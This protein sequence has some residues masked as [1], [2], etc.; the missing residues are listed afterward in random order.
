MNNVL[1]I[2]LTPT[3][4]QY[5]RLEALQQ[6][7]SQACNRLAPVV[8]QTRCWNR[9]ALHHLAY[10]SLRTEFPGLG[11]QMAC[12]AIYAV[13]KV[14]RH[15]Y[16]HPSSPF[17]FSR[18]PDPATTLPR[19]QF[20]PLAPVYYDRHTLSLKPGE[21]SIFSLE[22][23]LRC[24]VQLARADLERLGSEKIREIVLTQRSSTYTMTFR[25]ADPLDTSETTG[26]DSVQP[27]Q[28]S[29][30]PDYLHVLTSAEAISSNPHSHASR[31]A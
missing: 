13:S 1:R 18:Y 10:R 17:H 30:L 6:H 9:V 15:V 21:A 8:A 14:A 26:A 16:Q 23:R 4:E 24:P 2:D 27:A 29:L 7:F 3:D 11:S 19:L 25:F 22:G 31:V 5:R 28:K 12:N 20:A